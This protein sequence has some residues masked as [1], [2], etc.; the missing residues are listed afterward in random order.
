MKDCFS[1]RFNG[2]KGFLSR[3]QVSRLYTSFAVQRS[4]ILCHPGRAQF[5]TLLL[6]FSNDRPESPK[7]CA[8]EATIEPFL[9]SQPAK[10]PQ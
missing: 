4:I 3:V 6:L 5:H 1:R 9:A 8:C 10:S 7:L 2:A